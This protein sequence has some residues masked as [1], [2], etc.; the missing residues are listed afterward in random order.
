MD[1]IYRRGMGRCSFD[2]LDSLTCL[3]ALTS[4]PSS[5]VG[6]LKSGDVE[7]LHLQHGLHGALV[8]GGGVVL[9]ELGHEAGDDLPGEAEF[10]LQP[11]ALLARR[12]AAFVEAVPVEIEFVLGVALDLEGHG[13]GELEDGAAVQGGE[14]LAAELEDDGH[15]AAGLATVD[16][17]AGFAIKDDAV[18][19]AGGED[20]GV[21][22]GGVFG[23]VVEPEAGGDFEFH[24]WG[25][26]GVFQGFDERAVAGWTGGMILLGKGGFFDRCGFSGRRSLQN[27][28]RPAKGRAMGCLH[29]PH[30]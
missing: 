11:A 22:A 27:G 5:C 12:V 24:E 6:F 13:F 7:L 25:G 19:L 21:K 2:G 20:A 9:E 30:D 16:F 28:W 15:D 14:G 4:P 26:V 17:L 3:T 23:L 29:E 18:D 1:M 8:T 10:V